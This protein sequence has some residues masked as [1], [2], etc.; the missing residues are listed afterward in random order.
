MINGWG[1]KKYD[2][3]EADSDESS[4]YPYSVLCRSLTLYLLMATFVD[5]TK[6][7]VCPDSTLCH[8]D[9]IPEM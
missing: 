3:D 5:P 6:R 2:A 8:T 1:S 4:C 7:S 9:S